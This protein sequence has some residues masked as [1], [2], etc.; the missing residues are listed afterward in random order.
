[1]L[2]SRLAVAL[3]FALV[4]FSAHAVPLKDIDVGDAYYLNEFGSNSKVFV[5]RIDPATNRVKVRREDGTT[6]WAT[7]DRLLTPTESTSSEVK[8]A[9]GWGA[10]IIGG[11]CALSEDCRKAVTESGANPK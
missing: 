4:S 10:L 8:E 1:M 9:I 11:A 2:R 5:V 3:A 7:P 6:E